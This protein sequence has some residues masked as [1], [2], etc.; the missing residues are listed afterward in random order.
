MNRLLIAITSCDKHRAWQFAQRQTW[1]RD[2][3]QKVSYRFFLGNPAA[4]N[5]ENDEVFLDV[6]DDYLGLPLKTRGVS[7]WALEQGFN[8]LYKTDVDTLV[9]PPNLLDSGFEQYDY[10]GGLNTERPPVTFAS[11]GAGYCL[12]EKAMKLVA[13]N[14]PW[15]EGGPEDVWVA[16][17]LKDNG[18]LPQSD[19]RFKFYPGS[20]LDKQTISY[21]LTSVRGW[22]QPYSPDQMFEKYSEVKG[23]S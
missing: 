23:L 2:I 9:L 10:V 15:P 21:H 8:L 17:V 4:G 3:P 19:P 6:P 13:T 11:G 7:R 22:L 14:T 20:L 12:S 18:I 5:A 16:C 1:I